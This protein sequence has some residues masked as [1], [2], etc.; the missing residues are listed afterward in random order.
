MSS[1]LLTSQQI[2][3]PVERFLLEATA[4]SH[5]SPVVKI[6]GAFNSFDYILGTFECFCLFFVYGRFTCGY[7]IICV[8]YKSIYVNTANMPWD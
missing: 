4:A 6:S 5:R 3:V 8:L 7:A 2:K 1:D